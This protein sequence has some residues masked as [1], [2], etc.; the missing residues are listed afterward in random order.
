MFIN[1]WHQDLWNKEQDRHIC[2]YYDCSTFKIFSDTQEDMAYSKLQKY[3]KRQT[4][5]EFADDLYLSILGNFTKT[6]RINKG[7]W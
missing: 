3:W 4:S 5:F 7:S 1:C 2:Y 6:S